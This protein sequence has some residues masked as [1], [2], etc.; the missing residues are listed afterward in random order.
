MK[1]VPSDSS[2]NVSSVGVTSSS[3]LGIKV[4]VPR[5][6]KLNGVRVGVAGAGSSGLSR[7]MIDNAIRIPV[8]EKIL[9][10]MGIIKLRSGDDGLY[11]AT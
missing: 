1:V 6:I 2:G 10:P 4:S 11:I 7:Y 3:G 5:K 8:I 9:I